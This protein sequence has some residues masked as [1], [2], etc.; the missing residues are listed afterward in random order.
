LSGRIPVKPRSGMAWN[1]R[2]MASSIF[3]FPSHDKTGHLQEPKRGWT[4]I[5]EISGL[6]GVHLH[7]LRRTM[8]S[9]QTTNGASTAIEGKTLGHKNPNTAVMPG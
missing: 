8:G 2:Q 5:M 7:D 4:K 9:F 1:S 3:I 6:V